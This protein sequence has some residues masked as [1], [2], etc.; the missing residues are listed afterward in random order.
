MRDPKQPEP[1]NSR[2][3][4][5]RCECVGNWPSQTSDL[6]TPGKGPR[7]PLLPLRDC[8]DLPLFLSDILI[9]ENEKDSPS[10][11]FHSLPSCVSAL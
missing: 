2:M 3:N 5:L 11:P 8:G 4:K 1:L 9:D 7:N 6:P 10:F